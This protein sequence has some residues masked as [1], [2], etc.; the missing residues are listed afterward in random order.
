MPWG[1]P[2]S[3]PALF[4][5]FPAIVTKLSRMKNQLFTRAALCISHPFSGL[6]SIVTYIGRPRRFQ[7]PAWPY[8][9]HMD[10]W[11]KFHSLGDTRGPRLSLMEATRSLTSCQRRFSE[12]SCTPP[13]CLLKFM[14]DHGAS[15][16]RRDIPVR[17]P[18]VG[19]SMQ[20]Y[21]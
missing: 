7:R 9:L 13:V 12:A 8:H 18:K 11:T 3:S 1:R 15:K 21:D 17:S 6:L 16:R 10:S 2:S 5:L 20:M 14:P 19:A 4:S